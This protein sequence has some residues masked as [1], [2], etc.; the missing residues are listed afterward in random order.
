MD[1]EEYRCPNCATTATRYR[2]TQGSH[3]CTRC[4]HEWAPMRVGTRKVNSRKKW[5]SIVAAVVTVMSII[6][7][8]QGEVGA[9]PIAVLFWGIVLFF[10]WRERKQRSVAG[11]LETSD[12]DDST[13]ATHVVLA[14]GEVVPKSD[15]PYFCLKP[16]C[17]H[18]LADDEEFCI[19]CGTQKVR[20]LTDSQFLECG[21]CGREL[22]Q[23]AQFCPGCGTQVLHR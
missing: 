5:F 1:S 23:G 10:N 13:T 4:G 18:E 16:G 20:E 15:Q 7:W 9:T 8:T 21:S 6:A 11:E 3:I 12:S 17:G 14:S 22:A 19:S 2:A